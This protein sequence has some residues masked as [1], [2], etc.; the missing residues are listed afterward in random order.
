MKVIEFK[1]KNC[2]YE[3]SIRIPEGYDSV[4]TICP[5]CGGELVIRVRDFSKPESEEYY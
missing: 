1:C 2:D 4:R 5:N 3:F